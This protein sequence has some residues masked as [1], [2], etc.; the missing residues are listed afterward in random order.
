MVSDGLEGARGAG[1]LPDGS[2][3]TPL[4]RVCPGVGLRLGK[5]IGAIDHGAVQ[6]G[7]VHSAV[8]RESHVT[9]PRVLSEWLAVPGS[10][11]YAGAHSRVDGLIHR[12]PRGGRSGPSLPQQMYR[13]TRT[14]VARQWFGLLSMGSGT[15]DQPG[16]A[17]HS[18][19]NP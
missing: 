7:Q 13:V 1:W 6:V 12:L 14:S 9:F 4:Q 19:Q 5:Q 2:Q 16:R 18:P 11:H 8:I 15:T 3:Y 10:D 17:L